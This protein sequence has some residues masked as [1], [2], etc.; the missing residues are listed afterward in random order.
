MKKKY[1]HLF[2]LILFFIYSGTNTVRASLFTF[3]PDSIQIIFDRQQLVLPGE[4]FKIGI[5]SYH[6]NRK[7]RKTIGMRSGS[8]MWWHY[9]V[10]V[11][12]GTNRDGKITVNPQLMP[13]KGKYVKIKVSPKKHPKLFKQLLIPLNYE[14][15]LTFKP[16]NNYDK[17]PG[18]TIK[19][20]LISKFD[21]GRIRAYKKLN[22]NDE[23]IP[24]QFFINGGYWKKGKFTIDPDF[25]NIENHKASFVITSLRNPFV[26]DSFSVLLDYKHDYRLPFSGRSGF[27]GFSGSNGMSGTTG[28]NGGDGQPGQDGEP[29]YNAPDVGVWA[30][31]YFDSLLNCNIIYVFV[32]NFFTGEE[33]RY[34]V[35]PDGGSFLISS[36]GGE[37]G[38]G[39]NGGCGGDGGKGYDGRVWYEQKEVENVVKKPQTRKVEKKITKKVIDAEGKEKEVEE[40]VW[41]EETYYVDVVEKKIISI[42]HQEPGE[43]GGDGGNGGN[44]GF[45]GPGG[46]GGNIYLYFTND[47]LP[48]ENLF[49]AQTDGGSG[50]LNGNGGAGGSGGSGGYGEPNGLS[51]HSGN[52]G[53]SLIGW[54]PDGWDGE[55]FKGTTEE[56]YIIR[57]QDNRISEKT[58]EKAF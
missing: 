54:T 46:D 19:G 30:D 25:M 27:S 14:T 13:S 11:T 42:K 45:G 43:R 17:A 39:G 22:N 55:V 56:F 6:K 31:L 1:F 24:F 4:S 57:P 23:S 38:N 9:N 16:V 10:E 2:F 5:I 35:N 8:V 50:G 28:D 44:G 51:G 48:Y 58:L 32:Q 36:V 3:K 26:T 49:T 18:A 12:G 53:S 15:A 47:C 40:T 34:L 21:N 33:Y 41:I 29:G 37:G 52:S 20:V 7:T